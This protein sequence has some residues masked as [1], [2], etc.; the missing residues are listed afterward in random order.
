MT[1]LVMASKKLNALQISF[2]TI[3]L[4]VKT[5]LKDKDLIFFCFVLDVSASW[6]STGEESGEAPKISGAKAFTY[7]EIK[8]YTNN[9]K[10]INVIGVGG[11]G[12][13]NPIYIV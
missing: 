2:F 13:V 8:M 12:E 11:Y 10:E 4:K 6:G 3:I 7:D 9:F 1:H 5:C